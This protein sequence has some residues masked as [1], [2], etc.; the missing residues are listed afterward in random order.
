M[1]DAISVDFKMI[2]RKKMAV[3]SHETDDRFM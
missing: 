1:D 2:P 3:T